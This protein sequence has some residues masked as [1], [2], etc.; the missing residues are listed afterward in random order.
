MG[1]DYKAQLLQDRALRDAAKALVKADIENLRADMSSKSLGERTMDR[2]GEGAVDLYEEAKVLADDNK[3][4][5][6]TLVAALFV[7][8]ARHPLADL[9]TGK[10]DPGFF[11]EHFPDLVGEND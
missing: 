9:L 10:D 2:L 4:I 6:A 11:E 1:S 7:W 5:L 8:F 3:G